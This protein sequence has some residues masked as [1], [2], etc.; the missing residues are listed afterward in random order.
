[1]RLAMVVEYDGTEYFGWQIQPDRPTIQGSLEKALATI[2]GEKVRLDAAGRT[3]AG[4]HARGQVAAFST[5]RSVHIASLHRG[6]NALCGQ[7][8]VVR[9]LGAVTD[10]FDPRRE[11]RNRSYEYRIHNA[12]WPSPFS[13]RY[14]WHVHRELDA[15]AMR[16]AAASLVGERDF[17]SFQAADC[18][19]DNPVRR[20]LESDVESVGA[21]IV[22]RV[23]AT[24]FLRHMVRNIVG[25]LVE[26]GRGE[27]AADTVPA[28]L[29][30]RDRTLA[31]STA[32]PQGL[33]LVSVELGPVRRENA[34][35]RRFS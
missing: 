14:S 19:A 28:L 7:G 20:V 25:T 27:R 35:W 18:D 21:E 1:M 22:Y 12:P 34:S 17:S 15:A 26:V 8:I 33:C 30:L 6:V 23:R 32:P 29:D 2:L 16:R 24:S 9:E 31:G 3:D 5:E 10:G 4:V 13:A 11:A